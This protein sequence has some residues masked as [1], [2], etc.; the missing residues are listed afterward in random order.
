[1][2]AT[3]LL[4][5]ILTSAAF[6]SR[7]SLLLAANKLYPEA[8]PAFPEE[9]KALIR[10]VINLEEELAKTRGQLDGA[11][12]LAP[13]WHESRAAAERGASEPDFSSRQATSISALSSWSGVFNL[14]LWLI[15]G[16]WGS[17]SHYLAM[18]LPPLAVLPFAC[19]GASLTLLQ[20]GRELKRYVAEAL[21]IES[22]LQGKLRCW[23]CG[24][25]FDIPPGAR[26]ATCPYCNTE[27]EN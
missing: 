21:G 7:R 6:E 1:M 24:D 19:M 27:N 12:A 16:C 17:V 5:F 26:I 18:P 8:V 4:S 22:P 23:K 11:R 9:D 2:V 3:A 15:V 20:L 13:D 10:R 14:I 25:I